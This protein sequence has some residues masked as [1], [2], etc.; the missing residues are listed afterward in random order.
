MKKVEFRAEAPALT[1]EA[2]PRS[3][4]AAKGRRVYIDCRW[5]AS[6]GNCSLVMAGTAQEVFEAALAHATGPQHH[7]Q[8]TPDFRDALQQS[9]RE[10]PRG[11]CTLA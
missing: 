10:V 8:D 3:H 11:D 7:E 4:A 9:L 2:P 5:F 1:P 6:E